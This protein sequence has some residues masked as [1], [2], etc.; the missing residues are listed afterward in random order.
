MHRR[1]ANPS[2]PFAK[3][4]GSVRLR[5][6]SVAVIRSPISCVRKKSKSQG[7]RTWDSHPCK[8]RKDG[9]PVVLDICRRI[10]AQIPCS[11]H[12]QLVAH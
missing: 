6:F 2:A 10:G 4:R 12:E 9:P 11:N 5:T 1:V 8:E 7:V 3:E